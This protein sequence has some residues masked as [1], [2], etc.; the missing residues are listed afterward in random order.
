[1]NWRERL[2][3]WLAGSRAPQRADIQAWRDLCD[4]YEVDLRAARAE[5]SRYADALV[6]I[7]IKPNPRCEGCQDAERIAR[8]ALAREAME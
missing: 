8:K 5:L 1:M 3:D 7:A 2:A 6:V 4:E